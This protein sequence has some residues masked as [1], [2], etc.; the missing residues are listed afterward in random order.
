MCVRYTDMEYKIITCMLLSFANGLKKIH[1]EN[2]KSKPDMAYIWM[3]LNNFQN[4]KNEK[5]YLENFP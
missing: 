5:K 2:K 4:M 3:L 1:I